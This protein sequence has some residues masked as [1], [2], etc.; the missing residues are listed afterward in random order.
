MDSLNW[1]LGL[2]LSILAA[3]IPTILYVFFIRW[4]DRYEKE[5]LALMA[6]AFLWGGV[7]AILLAV[8][9]ELILGFPFS[10]A[11]SSQLGEIFQSAGIVPAVE[12]VAKAMGLGSFGESGI[13]GLGTIVFLRGGAFGFTHAFFTAITGAGLGYANSKRANSL[14]WMVPAMALGAAIAFHSLHNLGVSLAGELPAGFAIAVLNYM[15]GLILLLSIVVWSLVQEKRWI[16]EELRDEVGFTITQGEYDL[17]VRKRSLAIKKAGPL[18]CVGSRRISLLVEL[19]RLTTELA[20]K[21]HRLRS[22]DSS[23]GLRDSIPQLRGEIAK[24]RQAAAET[25]EPF[26]EV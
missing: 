1:G 16:A 15:T 2:T 19:S 18:A 13:R 25:M 4:L 6:A 11:G 12:E 20:F 3:V 17:V 24:L 9:V 26:V 5:P 22:G 21:K 8:V 14:H 7:P 23:A 10:A